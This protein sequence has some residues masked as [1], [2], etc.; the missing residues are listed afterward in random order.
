MYFYFCLS[1]TCESFFRPDNT[2]CTYVILNFFFLLTHIVHINCVLISKYIRIYIYLLLV[3]K[4]GWIAESKVLSV[5]ILIFY[6]QI[7]IHS[8]T[9]IF[10]H[11]F[12]YSFIYLSWC[13]YW[14]RSHA[15][16]IFKYK[17][18]NKVKWITPPWAKLL[19]V[20]LSSFHCRPLFQFFYS[21]P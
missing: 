16:V 20:N 5:T 21:L 15:C 14:K 10:L 11:L 13:V 6:F 12:I 17:K 19:N 9:I 4:G 7:S 2:T 8:F 18:K 1:L 3:V